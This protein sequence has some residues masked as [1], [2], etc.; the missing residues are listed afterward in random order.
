VCKILEIK[1]KKFR[2]KK[3]TYQRYLWTN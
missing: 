2:T 1:G 3:E